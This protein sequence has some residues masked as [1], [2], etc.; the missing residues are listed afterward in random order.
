MGDG[1]PLLH[2]KAHVWATH[3][4]WMERRHKTEAECDNFCLFCRYFIPLPGGFIEDWGGL[5]QS[6]IDAGWKGSL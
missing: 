4:R 1:K 6:G 3:T 2:D 5:F